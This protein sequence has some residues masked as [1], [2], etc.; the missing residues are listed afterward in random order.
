MSETLPQALVSRAVTHRGRVRA[1]NQD[2]VFESPRAGLWLVAD[3]IGGHAQGGVASRAI[4]NAMEA[5]AACC[6]GENLASRVPETLSVVHDRL[7]EYARDAG[8]DVVGSTVA[9]LVLEGEYFHAFWAGDSRV[10]LLR[11]HRLRRLSQDHVEPPGSA[12]AGALYRAVGAGVRLELEYVRGTL[13]QDDVFLLCSDGLNKTLDDGQ[14]AA[15][16]I[17]ESAEEACQ[18]LLGS[19]LEGGATDNVSCLTVHVH[20]GTAD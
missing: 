16:L 14:L 19:A 4:V 1:E 18:V 8:L 13:Y 12:A 15:I 7:C 9:V 17:R 11:D 3:G 2:A 6:Q 10:Y 20:A 5:L